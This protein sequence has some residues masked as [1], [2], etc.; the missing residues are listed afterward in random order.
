MKQYLGFALLAVQAAVMAL[1]MLMFWSPQSRSG[2]SYAQMAA[3]ILGFPIAFVSGLILWAVYALRNAFSGQHRDI[4]LLTS[5]AMMIGT[6]LAVA[7][8]FFDLGPR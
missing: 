4:L 1:M 5:T 6:M 3:A 2:D 7:T 8:G